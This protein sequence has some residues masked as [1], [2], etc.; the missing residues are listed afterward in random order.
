MKSIGF[1]KTQTPLAQLRKIAGVDTETFESATP[2]L[3]RSSSHGCMNCAHVHINRVEQQGGTVRIR[4]E[5]A[6]KRHLFEMFWLACAR[7]DLRVRHVLDVGLLPVVR[8]GANSG[9]IEAMRGFHI[10]GVVE[11]A[12]EGVGGDINRALDVTVASQ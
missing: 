1:E 9:Y 10:R 6:L 11:A 8:F 12:D 4:V 3:C 7:F 2:C 5:P